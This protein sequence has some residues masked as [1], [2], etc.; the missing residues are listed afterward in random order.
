MHTEADH[1]LE[2]EQRL[3][4]VIA[5]Y[6][7]A[8]AAGQTP[9]PQ[10][11]LARYPEL[12]PDL[13]EFFI[14]LEQIERLTAPLRLVLQAALQATPTPNENIDL[15]KA[16]PAEDRM[17]PEGLPHAFGGYE[18]LA[19]VGRGGMGVVYKA[20]QRSPGRLVALKML[21]SL[22]SPADL[23]RFRQEAEVIA[24][25]DHPHIV[26][27]YEVGE[28]EGRPYFSMKLMEG[29]TLKDVAV[30]GSESGDKSQ[31]A[32]DCGQKSEINKEACRRAA[33]W[34]ATVARAV[35]HMHQR[36]ILHRDLKPSNILLD[37]ARQPHVADFGLAKYVH[38]DASL[39]PS[40]AL[41]GTPGF[42]APE[43]TAGKKNKITT[44]TDIYGLGTILYALLTGRPP[45][46]GE[47]LLETL[48]QVK[49]R[50]PVLPRVRNRQVN[51]DL[52]TICL[53]CLEKE[54][55]R[56]YGSAEAVAEDL[57][58]WLAGEPIQARPT[59]PV[60]RLWR[61]SQRN[62]LVA[63]LSVLVLLLTVGGFLGVLKQWQVAVANE[64]QAEKER[65]EVRAL[66]D[67]LQRT[68]Y[69]AHMNLAQHAW[70]GAAVPRVIELLEQ[71]RPKIGEPDLRSFEW[72][73][74][75]RLC[76]GE[77]LTL[78]HAHAVYSVA[79][80][81]DGK[82]LAS[83]GWGGVPM[84]PGEVK[85]WDAQTGQQLLCLKG[86]DYGNVAFSPDGR[87]LASAGKVWD[88][89][90]GQEL[91]TLKRSGSILVFSP[92]GK[93]LASAGGMSEGQ[94]VVKVW[95]AATGQELFTC[96]GPVSSFSSVT[97]SPDGK[98]LASGSADHAVMVWDAETGQGLFAFKGHTNGV[99]SLAYSPDG[100]R[101]ASASYDQTVKVWDT[102]SCQELFSF[103]ASH[104]GVAF[105]PD[106]KQL[107]SASADHVVK[108]WDTQ[109]GQELLSFKGHTGGMPFG[110]GIC[111]AFS[112]DGKRLASGGDRTVKVWDAQK[113]VQKPLT[114]KVG[115]SAVARVAFS[116]DGK[117]FA[118]V[119]T[120]PSQE[121]PGEVKVCDAQT[122]RELLSFKGHTG[123]VDSVAFSPDGK[124]LASGS[125]WK[126]P[127]EVKVWDA[128]TG[129]ELFVLKGHTGQNIS[130]AFSPDGTRLAS[131][132][133]AS[134]VSREGEKTWPVG[135]EV[136][137]W[138]MQTGRELLCLKGLSNC[139]AFSPD[140]RCLA[141]GSGYFSFP[142]EVKVWDVLAGQELL[143]LKGHTDKVMS[144][145]FS[146]DGNRLASAASDWTVKVWDAR[147]GGELLTLKGH[148][149]GVRSVAFS[150]DSKRVASASDDKTVRIWDA[151]TGQELLTLEGQSLVFSPDGHLL[152]SG[153][154]DG[155]VKIWDGT[156]LEAKP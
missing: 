102:R 87:R 44:A 122:C 101:L 92:D 146:P 154:S 127:G 137:V 114:L 17:R 36:G 121:G 145:A 64:Q 131:G 73:Y 43:Q 95:D 2:R 66:D 103:T 144:V 26:P 153:G 108:V 85:M 38:A 20:R 116:P 118:S 90:T 50:E 130:V 19:Q 119:S 5:A 147:S 4:E 53:K 6:L 12:A 111:V 99:T 28:H 80:S 49:Q 107:A 150:P 45:F 40:G 25:L 129:Q 1:S 91:L 132:S 33:H 31:V 86:N 133:G 54:P 83:A 140:S 10:S 41:V 35:H 3:D 89:Q 139:V 14:S 98:Q 112:P 125:R 37:K 128:D 155:T 24:S 58:N 16:V 27:V 9:V 63:G 59:G 135:G 115:A 76:H 136:K 96:K 109:T 15:T 11:W 21:G 88:V 62:P 149:G 68:L 29:G 81:P 70:Q 47:T 97:Y 72:H 100:K 141:S 32:G 46:Q 117:R 55:E 22:D 93:R 143:T 51:R 79:Y 82:R 7:Q 30:R 77:L 142:S 13:A 126:E 39:A 123:P 65:D 60:E 151:Q 48:E 56:R 156:P 78:R 120:D 69:A 152:V 75:N 34:V 61:W 105:S 134:G 84:A 104:G 113:T 71:H 106:G 110:A 74:L 67:K 57:E 8:A 23:Q 18:L 94:Q 138:D 52:E 148:T 124:R 42:M